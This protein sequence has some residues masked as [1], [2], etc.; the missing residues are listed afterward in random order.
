MTL[1]QQ[2]KNDW[3]E[4]RYAL[5]FTHCFT[6]LVNDIGK[7]ALL[8]FADCSV[9]EHISV[10]MSVEVIDIS[11]KQIQIKERKNSQMPNYLSRL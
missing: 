4:A 5:S 10:W 7:Y 3:E 6:I 2:C 9:T 8:M 1:P 11:C